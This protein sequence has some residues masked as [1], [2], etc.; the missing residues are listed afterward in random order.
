MTLTVCYAPVFIAIFMTQCTPVWA[1]WD[2]VLSQTNC[3][4]AEIHELASVAVN[5]AL[6][7]AVVLTPTPVIW[8]LQMPTRKKVGVSAMFSLGFL[9]VVY[10]YR[11]RFRHCQNTNPHGSVIG[12]MIWRLITTSSNEE[13]DLVYDLYTLALQSHLELWLGIIAANLPVL[14]P[15]LSRLKLSKITEY[16][17]SG[18]SGRNKPDRGPSGPSV[19][20]FGSSGRARVR[21]TD[22]IELLSHGADTEAGQMGTMRSQ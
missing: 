18:S 17:S 11:K 13:P 10:P 15:L 22:D 9:Y 14:G 2:Q 19:I 1:A 5:L 12:V 7:L 6:D 16:L 4:P 3:R 20:T 21:D 8:T